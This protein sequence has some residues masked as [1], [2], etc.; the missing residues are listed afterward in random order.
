MWEK[1]K[2]LKG[3]LLIHSL[4]ITIAS[5]VIYLSIF[6]LSKLF[7]LLLVIFILYLANL[8]FSH[9]AKAKNLQ[10][11]VLSSLPIII[12]W[13]TLTLF[14]ASGKE[15]LVGYVLLFCLSLLIWFINAFKRIENCINVLSAQVFS[16]AYITIP[17]SFSLG[18]LFMDS[19]GL[20]NDGRIWL[21]YL[22]C[23]SKGADVGGYFLGSWLGKRPLAPTISPRKT[24][25][26]AIGG[27]VFSIIIS[28][29]FY[30]LTFII[31]IS[32]FSISFVEA[33]FLGFGLSFLAQLGDLSESVLKRDA[34]LKD[35]SSIPAVGGVL[36]ILDSLIFTTPLLYCYLMIW[37]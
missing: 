18:I 9:L 30:A 31:P 10:Y 23:V 29:A 37:R 24:I 15:V 13:P 19:V 25:E 11:S 2:D 26:G 35:S 3:R 34:K 36:D 27:V 4:T 22:I 32:L 16:Q 21:A 28:M 20:K 5:L 8:E 14:S 7:I 1:F 12:L 6:P 17:L 33:L